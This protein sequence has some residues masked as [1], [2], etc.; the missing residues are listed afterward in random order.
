MTIHSYL[1]QPS[2]SETFPVPV[3]VPVPDL[4][5]DGDV[6]DLR[7]G[8]AICP[9]TL[10]CPSP[11][12]IRP[13]AESGTLPRPGPR[14]GPRP[15]FVGDGDAP[16]VPDSEGSGRRVAFAQPHGTVRSVLTPARAECTF[17]ILLNEAP[18][19]LKRPQEST[20]TCAS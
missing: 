12:P 4:P 5:G 15:R 18:W 6:R 3:T 10:L 16:P 19:V 20:V 14:P 8:G 7:L 17:Y 2:L 9:P 1:T 11:S 13:P